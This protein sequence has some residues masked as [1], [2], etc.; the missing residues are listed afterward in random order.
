MVHYPPIKMA[1][2]IVKHF[3]TQKYHLVTLGP[4]RL[5]QIDRMVFFTHV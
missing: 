2:Q 1:D 4:N 3:A 5:V